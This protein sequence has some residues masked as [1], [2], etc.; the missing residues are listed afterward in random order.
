LFTVTLIGVVVQGDNLTIIG[1][2]Y[3]QHDHA[4][5]FLVESVF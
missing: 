3:V 4:P 1:T 2:F 5:N